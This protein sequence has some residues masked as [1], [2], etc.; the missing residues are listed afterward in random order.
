MEDTKPEVFV[1]DEEVLPPPT[2]P[3]DENQRN[4]HPGGFYVQQNGDVLDA[5]GAK[6]GIAK[7][8]AQLEAEKAPAKTDK[9]KTEAPAPAA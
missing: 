9:A 5:N 3:L 1:V 6:I 4:V 7:S 8:K 2:N